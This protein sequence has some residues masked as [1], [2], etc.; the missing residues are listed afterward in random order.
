MTRFWSKF[1]RGAAK[2]LTRRAPA[3]QDREVNY[4]TESFREILSAAKALRAHHSL[5]R[6]HSHF[7][8]M[9]GYG[10]GQRYE[11]QSEKMI[12]MTAAI[13]STHCGPE[14]AVMFFLHLRS[15]DLDFGLRMTNDHFAPE[16]AF[17]RQATCAMDIYGLAADYAASGEFE[18]DSGPFRGSAQVLWDAGYIGTPHDDPMVEQARTNLAAAVLNPWAKPLAH[19]RVGRL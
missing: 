9:L 2:R 12:V 17:A 1:R 7:D 8:D 4:C 18:Q 3:R 16:T 5:N 15:R 14:A 10:L 19:V 11:R 13:L 6:T